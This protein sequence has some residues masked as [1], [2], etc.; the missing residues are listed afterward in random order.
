MIPFRRIDKATGLPVHRVE[1]RAAADAS[2]TETA[3]KLC[4]GLVQT[5]DTYA[6]STDPHEKRIH[7]LWM[8]TEVNR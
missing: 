5:L 3:A 1:T 7:Q 6:D 8:N 2:Y 4:Q